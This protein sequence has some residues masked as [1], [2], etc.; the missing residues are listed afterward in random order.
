MR[1]MNC[2]KESLNK[3]KTVQTG[4]PVHKCCVISLH[5]SLYRFLVSNDT[6]I[7][8]YLMNREDK[9]RLMI[10]DPVYTFLFGHLLGQS[11]PHNTAPLMNYASE[12]YGL[13]FGP[14]LSHTIKM[15]GCT[16]KE[17]HS[18]NR[19]CLPQS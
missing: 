11:L 19:S 14:K 1:A 17:D 8:R 15:N 9:R 7:Q 12:K 6:T 10:P 4:Q 5:Y 13:L 2:Y 16:A 3:R 18:A